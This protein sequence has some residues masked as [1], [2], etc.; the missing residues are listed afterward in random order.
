[1]ET[2]PLPKQRNL[3]IYD[4][5]DLYSIQKLTESIIEINEHDEHLTKLFG[6]YNLN[7]QPDPI[8]IHI[9][10]FGG[11]VYQILGLISVIETSKVPIWTISTGVSMSAGLML[12]ISGHKRFAHKYS[13]QLYHQLSSATWGTLESIKDDVKELKRLQKIL[14]EIITSKTKL[15]KK[16]LKEIN[17]L[18]KDWFLTPKESLELG[19]IDEII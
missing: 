8:K 9:D 10:Y 5:I 6:V 1:M 17:L 14:E 15:T 16:K 13:T 2:L 7:Y 3:Y 12:L 11:S 18:K 19:I 4:G